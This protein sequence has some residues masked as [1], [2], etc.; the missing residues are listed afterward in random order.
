MKA[1]SLTGI[2]TR[3]ASTRTW[4][5]CAC[6]SSSVAAR[7]SLTSRAFATTKPAAF[8]SRGSSNRRDDS[9]SNGR[10]RNRRILVY[11]S[12]G[13][14][15]LGASTLAFTDDI[16]NGYE[17][18]ER[19]GRVVAGLALCINDYR[20]TLNRRDAIDDEEEKDKLLRA[21]H[22][23]C[24]ERTLK[25]LE[26]N[27]GIFIKL[28][29]H[30]SAMN[31]L[32]PPEWTTT[33]IPLQDKCP[34]SPFDLI[35]KMFKQDTQEDL[36]AY[37]SD[38]APEPIGAASLAQVHLATIKETGRQVAVKVQHPEL[39]SY[40]PLDMALTRYTFTTLKK[41]FPE[42]DL[43]WLSYEMEQSL[44]LELDFT[45]EAKNAN[46]MREHFAEK[47]PE[48]PL[49]I[50]E[51]LWARKRILVMA[52][53][54][55]S[56]PDD[57][58]YLDANG[59]DRDEVSA[60]MGRI[61][62]EMIFGDGAPLHCDP[63]GGNIA[64]RKNESRRRFGRGPN[65]DIILYDHGLYRDIPLDL[66]RSYAKMWLAVIDGDMARMKTYA[67][68]VAG[69]EDK[70]FPLFASAITGRDF[71]VVSKEGSILKARS[72]EE[73]VSM[74]GSLQEGLIVDLVQLLA[75]VPR[76]ILLI[77][78]TNDLTR[79][80][81]E[82]LQ[83]REGPI[84]SFM[85]LAR[86]CMRTVYLEQLEN[87]R[88]AGSL[89]WPPNAVRVFAAWLGYMRVEVK[90]EAFEMWLKIKRILGLKGSNFPSG[91]LAPPSTSS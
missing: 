41:V 60:T 25:V 43:E 88:A 2:A 27:G 90:L 70:D 85:I 87:I 9:G 7:S 19:T 55:G 50:P 75:R 54:S 17:S 48:M 6:P 30:L 38:F 42:Y 10:S 67:H 83:T 33:F 37:F 77:L 71:S 79:S 73:E 15:A 51:V 39:E 3:A 59:I 68:E 89:F 61:F 12:S 47:M 56:R 58:A 86:Y 26:K 22:K 46:R 18:V 57:L 74:S 69:I 36:S 1:F 91:S 72:S 14:A 32:L 45:E 4:T 66:R 13:T 78:K 40:L 81:D 24:A 35:E 80:L 5:C 53:E 28:G 20:T 76:I 44:P 52:C 64:I 62:N 16:K 63:H 11:A 23:R 82:N 31:Y 84:R 21:C 34:V 65:F 8:P 49:V 29:Q